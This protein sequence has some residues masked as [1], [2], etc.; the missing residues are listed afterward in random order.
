MRT[1]IKICG[2]TRPEDALSA[3]EFGADALGFVFW[4]PSS[5]SIEPAQAVEIVAALPPLASIVGLFVDAT[6]ADVERVLKQVPLDLLQFHGDEPPEL[7]S[8]FARRYIKALPMG[9]G[10]D[11]LAYARRYADATA[12]LLD[13]HALGG[14]GGTGQAFDWRQAPKALG[15]PMIVAGGLNAGNVRQAIE[16]CKPYAVDVSS[17]VEA[18]KG[19]KDPAR[20]AEFI[21]EVNRVGR[22]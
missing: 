13:S 20:M 2:I 5:R 8:A 7:C 16:Q 17:G 19:I 10:V 9:G 15:R 18:A 3:I 12:F 4:K 21:N 22:D 1:R 6:A 14:S 11:P